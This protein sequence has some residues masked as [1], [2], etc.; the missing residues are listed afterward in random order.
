[1]TSQGK[2]E[3][4]EDDLKY[5]VRKMR[6][7]AIL[8]N[9]IRER[10]QR[11]LPVN[12]V[13]RTLYQPDLYLQAYGKL[14]R[15]DGAM[16]KGA[17]TE[18]VDGMSMVKIENIIES[19]RFERYEWTPVRR[20]YIDKKNGSKRP[21]GLP[22]Y[23][24]KLLQEV[25]R[26]ILEAY[27]EPKFSKSS[28]GFRPGRGCHTALKM[29]KQKG[30]GTKWFIEGD[31]K[32]CFD[33]IDHTVLLNIIKED[34]KDNRFI[35]LVQRALK[36]GYLEDWEYH[37]TYSGVPQGSIVGPILSNLVLNKL[38]KFMEEQIL[39]SFNKGERRKVNPAYSKITAKAWVAK[40][41]G[42]LITAKLLNQQAQQIPSRVP[43]DP[44]FKRL[45]YVR[46]AD[47]WLAGVTGTEAEAML[48]KDKIATYL[49]DELKLEL[50]AEKTLI[51]HARSEKAKFLGYEVHTL[52]C[53]TKHTDGQRSI[54][55]SI[56]LRIPEKVI[57]DNRHKYM[58]GGKPVHRP[59][60]M[61]DE[62][63]SIVNQYQ[64]EYRGVAQYYKMAYNLHSMSH[65]KYTMEVSLVKTLANKYKTTCSKI[66]RK[67][68]TT[69]TI[70]EGNY[71]VLRVI[72][73]RGNKKPLETHFG[74]VPLVWN[75]WVSIDDNKEVRL[76][77]K[78]SEVV[79]R[80]LA[81]YC[82]LCGNEGQ[83]EM[84]HIRKLADVQSKHGRDVPQ[85][86]R[87]MSMRRRK[88]LA[89]CTDCH[90]KIHRGEYDGTPLRKSVGEPRDIERVMRGSE[91]GG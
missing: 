34:F 27:Y 6:N 3:Q 85:W 47:D 9:I 73:H 11:G 25:I 13:Y 59:E 32:G 82:E 31:I 5:K 14:Y 62:P 60:R 63:Y 18:T 58:R 89:V 45:W 7:A 17:T 2:G 56:G 72:V 44:N 69:I 74:A 12:N 10:A 41:K 68:G 26:L 21:L 67:Y 57:K 23:R 91:R 39:P 29:V 86:K 79:Q 77:S 87:E 65:L 28:H 50:S 71:K 22:T 90:Y 55:G 88:S 24:D 8:L 78:R 76:W 54:N 83:I 33:R 64:S 61:K 52:H 43:N 84:H 42:D 49:R 1:M 35:L 20:T 30:R 36:A 80:L 51:T 66:Y 4:A 48:I 40:T 37:Q 46:Y 38:D 75:T 81:N 53:D 70:P 16:T 15:N 19:L